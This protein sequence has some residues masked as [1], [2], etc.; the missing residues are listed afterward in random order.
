MK[1]LWKMTDKQLR[2]IARGGDDRAH[3]ADDEL[4]ARRQFRSEQDDTP[5]IDYGG[6]DRPG[7]Y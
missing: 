2:R 7:E 4:A 5:S 3:E 1:P 6:W